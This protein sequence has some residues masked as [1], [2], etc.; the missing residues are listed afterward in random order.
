MSRNDRLL[1]IGIG[2]LFL[3][4]IPGI[5]LSSITFA[6]LDAFQRD[7]NAVMNDEYVNTTQDLT[8][9]YDN[10]TVGIAAVELLL[11]QVQYGLGNIT[12][13]PPSSVPPTTMIYEGTLRWAVT[14][15]NAPV[16]TFN[17]LSAS[18]PNST[19]RAYISSLDGIPF[20]VIALDTPLL[21]GP[22]TVSG[23]NFAWI[24]AVFDNNMLFGFAGT[25]LLQTF[26]PSSLP[27]LVNTTDCDPCQRLVTSLTLRASPTVTYLRHL[28]FSRAATTPPI[29][30]DLRPTTHFIFFK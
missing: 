21:N 6:S 13:N 9:L 22:I 2:L 17:S 4:F 11:A 12:M 5:I 8:A 19:Y 7:R 10:V 24:V 16:P 15:N 14:F 3:M 1:L 27:M 30:F 26:A 20:Y 28:L 25:G 18:T 29:S 23:N